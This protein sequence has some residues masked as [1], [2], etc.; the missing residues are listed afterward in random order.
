MGDQREAVRA[1]AALRRP[2]LD[3]GIPRPDRDL[4]AARGALLAPAHQDRPARTPC[5]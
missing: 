4:L 1:D 2:A 5:S 3:P